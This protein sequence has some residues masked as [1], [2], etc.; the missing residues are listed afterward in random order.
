MNRG[1]NLVSFFDCVTRTTKLFDP[2]RKSN[3]SFHN[4]NVQQYTIKVHEKIYNLKSLKF[5]DYFMRNHYLLLAYL[6]FKKNTVY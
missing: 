4:G 3:I 6:T 1:H 5:E 2:V